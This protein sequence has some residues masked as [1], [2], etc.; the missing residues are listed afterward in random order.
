M[1]SNVKYLNTGRPIKEIIS[2]F[3][4]FILNKGRHFGT[5]YIALHNIEILKGDKKKSVGNYIIAPSTF[6]QLS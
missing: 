1:N 5:I 4:S 6:N 2:A 3:L